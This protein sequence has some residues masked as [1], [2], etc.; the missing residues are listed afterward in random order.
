MLLDAGEIEPRDTG[1]GRVGIEL[2]G[3]DRIQMVPEIEKGAAIVVQHG[4]IAALGRSGARLLAQNFAVVGRAQ[5]AGETAHG[6][7]VA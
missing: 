6:H 7:A 3:R 5:P 1:P 4:P 2:S